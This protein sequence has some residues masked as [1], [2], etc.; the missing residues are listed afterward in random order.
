MK[1]AIP[2]GSTPFEQAVKQHIDWITGQQK[3]ATPI[4]T[5][6]STATTADL[7]AKVNQIINRMQGTS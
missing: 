1:P 5:L 2:A 6:A 7:I 3:N 4:A